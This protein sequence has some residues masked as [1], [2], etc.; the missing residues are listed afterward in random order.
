MVSGTV[1]VSAAAT[2][3]ESGIAGVQ[4]KLDGSDLG[5][6]DVTAPF[7]VLWDT[8]S[9]TPGTYSL[10]A[11]ARDQAGNE[12]ES[13]LVL[14]TV[15]PAVQPR[16]P[17]AG[18]IY[19]STYS[20][21]T[22]TN[23][24]QC[25]NVY[26]SFADEDILAYDTVSGCWS[27]YFDGSNVGLGEVNSF[28]IMPDGSILL[29]VRDPDELPG[30]G[31]VDSS[32]IVR[33]IP[34]A[35]GEN[36]TRGTFELY[37][38]GANVG[39]GPSSEASG[40]KID[41]ISMLPDGRLVISTS[42]NYSVPGVSG[43]DEDLIAFTATSLGMATSG[44]W[45]LYFDGSLVGLHDG[46]K[47]EDVEGVSIGDNGDIYLSTNGDFSVPGLSGDGADIFRCRP[48]STG[49]QT[50]CTYD[51]VWRGSEYGLSGHSLTGI[52]IAR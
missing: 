41:A 7:S 51:L 11:L 12:R 35:L 29:A 33:F 48:L 23:G 17:S 6:E 39:L 46:S 10:T 43:Q 38:K 16:T 45:E 27:L 18:T 8:S 44:T 21:G 42:H 31:S 32:D 40:E 5:A 26:Y 9:A 36:N 15:E 20:K 1:T 24:P 22:I 50:S 47:D 28:H 4:F 2:D 52:H 19:V 25:N 13:S 30:L 3:A 37:F 34:T 49:S 14:V